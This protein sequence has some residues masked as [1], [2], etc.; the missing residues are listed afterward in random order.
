[1]KR[2][3]I[4]LGML[5]FLAFGYNFN[6]NWINKGEPNYNDPVKLVIKNG[7]ISPMLT[8]PSGLVKLKTKTATR[9]SNGYFE[10]WGFGN[11]SIALLIKPINSNKIRVI[12]KKINLNKR[13]VYTKS[14]IF[15]RKRAR[16]NGRPFIGRYHSRSNNLFTAISK[17]QI[18]KENGRLY[19]KAW[20]NTPR[21]ERALGIARA[22]LKG[23][24]LYMR[25]ERR[26]IFVKANIQ[27]LNR[28]GQNRFKRIR[29]NIIARNL[30]TDIS[31]SQTIILRRNN[32]QARIEPID[33]IE[34]IFNTIYGY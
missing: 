26:D 25:W 18:Y 15:A 5:S 10:V 3:L 22:V 4:L 32:Y 8:R 34:Q 30:R 27:G 1:M 11:K 9:V 14:F 24:R 16:S 12:A 6:G 17:V 2:I 28:N 23:N 19:V 21:G 13:K 31:N 29:L 33:Q 7:Q 20:R